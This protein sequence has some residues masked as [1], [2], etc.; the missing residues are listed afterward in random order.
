M[1]EF[2]KFHRKLFL[3]GQTFRGTFLSSVSS[4]EAFLRQDLKK[5]VE[6]FANSSVVLPP[7]VMCT[8]QWCA[9]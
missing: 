1:N 4:I 3:I 2:R 5:A 8:T 6:K 7:H 9:L